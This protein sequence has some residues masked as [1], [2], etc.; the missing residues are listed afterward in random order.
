VD[1]GGFLA[2]PAGPL[3]WRGRGQRGAARSAARTNDVDAD[4]QRAMM[5]AARN[6]TGLGRVSLS[7]CRLKR[8]APEVSGYE[9]RILEHRQGAN[10]PRYH[11][12]RA[13][14][15]EGVPHGEIRDRLAGGHVT[16]GRSAQEANARIT[17][18]LQ[19]IALEALYAHGD[20]EG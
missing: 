12:V 6:T 3:R 2:Y 17:A 5:T 9:R 8:L 20:A 4:E 15:L 14:V 10:D 11:E 16:G 7:G 1:G 18:I 13:W 19:A